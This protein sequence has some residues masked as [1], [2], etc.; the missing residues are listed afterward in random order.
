MA[1]EWFYY[2]GE[3][4]V[5]P[6]SQEQLKELASSG[7]LL[8]ESMIWKEGLDKPVPARKVKGLFA[9]AA[10]PNGTPLPQAAAA[11]SPPPL[12]KQWYY[13]Q[14]GNR[15]GP[16]G[17]DQLKGLVKSGQVSRSIKVWCEGMSNWMTINEIPELAPSVGGPPP[18]TA[19]ALTV[20]AGP[21]PLDASA[22]S[23][24]E[25]DFMSKLLTNVRDP[26]SRYL[27]V[28]RAAL[29]LA[30]IAC[31]LPWA[32]VSGKAKA[33]ARAGIDVAEGYGGRRMKETTPAPVVG[34]DT[35]WGYFLIA[36]AAGGAIL[37]FRPLKT[38]PRNNRL[39]STALGAGIIATGIIVFLTASN[40]FLDYYGA[41]EEARD[42]EFA[43]FYVAGLG[44]YL[45]IAAGVA[46]CVCAI[47]HKWQKV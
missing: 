29:V 40:I 38:S 42:S 25:T 36:I 23:D 41:P 33:R 37:S 11:A 22:K 10:T 34:T 7:E 14:G 28:Y 12:G 9:W 1:T 8:P 6:V 16:V 15:Q 18:L 4:K 2:R 13:A 24:A 31:S 43:K 35:M 3:E 44:V 30:V 19:P 46:A 39:I 21:P 45:V 47:K 27:N 32:Q 20:P 5:G 17:E 26:A